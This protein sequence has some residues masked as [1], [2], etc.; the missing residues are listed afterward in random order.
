MGG[1]IH[2]ELWS[3]AV[4][5]Q[6]WQQNGDFGVA[7]G[8]PTY[9]AVVCDPMKEHMFFLPSFYPNFDN[10]S[11]DIWYISGKIFFNVQ[12]HFE[13]GQITM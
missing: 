5:W 9:R 11:N 13:I 4:L 6:A 2:L 7:G 8:G 10:L 12:Q 1:G 3:G